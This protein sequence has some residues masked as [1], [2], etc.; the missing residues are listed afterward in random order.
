MKLNITK[1]LALLAGLLLVVACNKTPDANHNHDHD[2]GTHEDAHVDVVYFTEDQFKSMNVKVSEL[3]KRNIGSYVSA[4]GVL[5]VPPQNEAS[6]TAIIGAN[7]A[8]IKV[9]EGQKVRKGQILVTVSHP[10]LIQLQTDYAT[11][12]NELQYLEKEFLRQKKLYSENVGSGKDFQKIESEYLS[13]KSIV[14]GLAAQLKLFHLSTESIQNGSISELVGIQ[15]PINGYVRTVEIKTG[16]YVSPQTELFE[17][18]NI[19]HIHADLMVF[20]KDMHKIREGQRV[21]FRVESEDKAEMEAIIFSV[22]KNFEQDPKAIHLHADIENKK[23]LLLPGMYVRG[24]ILIDTLQSLAVP[25]E[26]VVQEAEKYFIFSATKVKRN[27][28]IEWAFEPIEVQ[29]GATDKGWVEITDIGPFDLSK[30]IA[31]NSAYYLMGEMKKE[32][33]EHT[34]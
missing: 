26:A 16:Q 2:H 8:S 20:E 13:K 15:S 6:V 27:G 23:G 31:W 21:R 29:I 19:D 28:N 11:N 10:D 18:V 32:E 33:T 4:N 25:T 30:K 17:I 22:G 1:Y 5:E 34:H 7:V 3:S 14:S 9:I 24:E 12:W